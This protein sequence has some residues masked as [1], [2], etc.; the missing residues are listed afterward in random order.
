MANWRDE[1]ND[2]VQDERQ[3]VRPPTTGI[4]AAVKIRPPPVSSE[5]PMERRV[6][7]LRELDRETAILKIYYLEGKPREFDFVR[8]RHIAA[9]DVEEYVG[10]RAVELVK[11]AQKGTP[12]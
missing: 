10:R 7:A 4:G 11:N 2:A 9:G 8:D 12:W 6:A 5:S 1:L 3:Y